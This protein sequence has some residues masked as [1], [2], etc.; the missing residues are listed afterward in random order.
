MIPIRLF[1]LRRPNVGL[2]LTSIGMSIVVSLG[3][4]APVEAQ[5]AQ[6]PVPAPDAAKQPP[7]SDGYRKIVA[8]LLESIGAGVAGE[9][10][11]MSMAQETLGAIAATGT[12][13]TEEIQK[14][15]VDE[16]VSEFTDLFSG[17]DYLTNIYAPLY[18][19]HLSETELR[20]ILAF[21]ESP[22]GQKMISI[23]PQISQT[24]MYSIQRDSLERV[25][26]FQAKVDEK[27]R[28]A[29]VII[30]P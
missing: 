17:V 21:Y 9:Q 2:L 30:E 6:A 16:A 27:L 3:A 10:V 29:G 5:E 13:I 7:V 20:E 22:A 15:V 28:A 14:I 4:A 18:A 26:D 8:E 24:A 25:P 19:A 23:V 1:L 11:A 12:P